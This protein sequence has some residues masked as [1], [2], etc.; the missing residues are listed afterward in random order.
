MEKSDRALKIESDELDRVLSTIDINSRQ[1][2]STEVLKTLRNFVERVMLKIYCDDNSVDLGDNWESLCKSKKYCSEKRK[3]NFLYNFLEKNLN[4]ISGH[5][6][7]PLDYSEAVFIS[8][9]DKLLDIKFFLK[10]NYNF[11]VLNNLTLYPLNLDNTFLDYY[12]I[13]WNAL[14]DVDFNNAI[15][16]KDNSDVFYV[17][18]KKKIYFDNHLM[19]EIT[20]T[21]AFENQDKN[22]RFIAFSKIDVFTNY[23]IRASF[24]EKTINVFDS[25]ISI[26]VLKS[27]TVEIR[28]CELEKM[29]QILN[30][31]TSFK[32]TQ[33]E[34][35][36]LMSLIKKFHISFNDMLCWDTKKFDY[37]KEELRKNTGAT[38][39][40]IIGMLLRAKKI[41]DTNEVGSNCLRYLLHTMRNKC[42][43]YQV[44]EVKNPLISNLKLKNGTLQFENFPFCCNLINS[45]QLIRDVFESIGYFNHEDELPVKKLFSFCNETGNLYVKGEELGDI[46]YLKNSFQIFNSRLDCNSANLEIGF[47]NKN[48]FSEYN[49]KNT[50]EVI[51]KLKK[52]TNIGLYGYAGQATNWINNNR[53]EIK[54]EEK[55]VALEK[56]FDKSRVFLIHGPAGTGKSTLI[57]FVFKLLG[58]VKKL[59]LAPTYP[60]LESMRR[61]VEDNTATYLTIKKFIFNKMCNKLLFDIVVIDECSVVDN[62]TMVELLEV[63]KTKLL[64][65]SGDTHQIPSIEFGNWFYIAKSYLPDYSKCELTGVFRTQNDDLKELW[66]KVRL[67]DSDISD[68]LAIKGFV[69]KKLGKSIFKKEQEDEIILCLNY[70]GLYGVNFINSCLQN[71]NPNPPHNW[72]QYK[73]K[74]DDPVLFSDVKRFNKI[75]YN[76]LKG[77]IKG[78]NECEDGIEF[79]VDIDRVISSLAFESSDIEFVKNN[80]KT[81]TIKFK[82]YN[83]SSNVFDKDAN[84]KYVVPFHIAYA[85]SI[86]K[87]QGLEYDSVKVIIANDIEERISHNIFYTAITRARKKLM[88]YWTP[89]SESAVLKNFQKRFTDYDANVLKAKNKL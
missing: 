40:P 45:K 55:I 37:L 8:Y 4:N 28:I 66:K 11:D 2:V 7:I 43:K 3:Y 64:I 14:T 32:K 65:V 59:C 51:K 72:Y 25:I 52:F 38:V 75:T 35:M 22:D 16:D 63:L 48:F 86:H 87:S 29:A 82:V 84:D 44:D 70:D 41:T 60:A 73:F 81:T 31:Y 79:V 9:Y 69:C 20:L 88:I 46:E 42:L 58:N 13:I 56:M 78:I 77:V 57:K 71:K 53:G 6:T 23:S 19:Y 27:Y 47:F 15:D 1:I 39:F 24:E 36:F 12:R 61:R 17:L 26:K 67:F 89:E 50:V 74:V 34:Y 33:K 85:V 54:G 30:H 49:E 18:K 5:R 62:R 80:D 21:S 76:N 68:F 10:D 83:H